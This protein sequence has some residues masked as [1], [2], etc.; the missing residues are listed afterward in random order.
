MVASVRHVFE[1]GI[2]D[3]KEKARNDWVIVHPGMIV[4]N[5]SQVYWTQ[6]VEVI[7]ANEGYPGICRFLK[8]QQA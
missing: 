4:L 5:A 1:V 3:Y 2:I 6:D 7:L 8:E